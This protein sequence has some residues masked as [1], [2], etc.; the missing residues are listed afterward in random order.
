MK[1]KFQN[2]TKAYEAKLVLD[3]VTLSFPDQ[4]FVC[5]TGPSGAGKTT[6]FRLLLHLTHPDSGEIQ[7]FQDSDI[8]SVVFQEDRLL[9]WITVLD[10]VLLAGERTFRTQTSSAAFRNKAIRILT[11]LGL[12]EELDSYP[13]ELSGGMARRVAIARA[14]AADAKIYLMD[15]PT[16][17]LDDET[18]KHTLEVIR[19]YTDQ[20]VDEQEQ[21]FGRLLIMITHNPEETEGAQVITLPQGASA[22]DT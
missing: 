9:P 21:P 17:G 3:R 19:R 10:N 18:R 4:G 22:T 20:A 15:E 5:I 16:R 2:V 7:V 14:L 13:F 1:I 8:F 11:E 6:V 12:G